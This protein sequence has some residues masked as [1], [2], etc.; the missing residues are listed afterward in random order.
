MDTRERVECS[1]IY[2]SYVCPFHIRNYGFLSHSQRGSKL[3]LIR[4]LLGMQD[5][6]AE[7]DEPE[8][9]GGQPPAAVVHAC[10]CCADGVLVLKLA[11]PRPSIAQIM[12]MTMDQ[13]RQLPLPFGRR[14]THIEPIKC[15]GHPTRRRT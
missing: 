3:P 14:E 10:P 11:L 15:R 1:C 4:Q 5:A 9:G 6:A 2:L 12:Q 7:E 13:L 8:L